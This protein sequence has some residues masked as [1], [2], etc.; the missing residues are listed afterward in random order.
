MPKKRKK[1]KKNRKKSKRRRIRIKRK[2]SIKIKKKSR[3][4]RKRKK[5]KIRKRVKRIEITR[6]TK[7]L[8]A[9]KQLAQL[10]ELSVKKVLSFILQPFFK[11][12]ENF[13]S[14]KKLPFSIPPSIVVLTH[15]ILFQKRY[16]SKFCVRNVI[17]PIL[18]TK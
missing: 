7:G 13:H 6:K 18:T 4:S 9:Y 2:R 5:L 12:Y 16:F 14:K 11:I 17:I 3:K 8:R 15:K 10:Q 1:S